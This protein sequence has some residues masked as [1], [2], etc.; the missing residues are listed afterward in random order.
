M[1]L[2]ARRTLRPS[3][4]M[5]PSHD[6]LEQAATGQPQANFDRSERRA[7][8]CESRR[9]PG[10]DRDAAARPLRRR[11]R[12]HRIG[13]ELTRTVPA[14]YGGARLDANSTSA[15]SLTRG[16]GCSCA[17][18]GVRAQDTGWWT[19]AAP[20]SAVT[21]PRKGAVRASSPGTIHRVGTT[22]SQTSTDAERAVAARCGIRGAKRA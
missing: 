21:A 1:A 20:A 12:G 22:W 7:A 4:R 6:R 11:G 8:T 5:A 13:H 2:C 10:E 3:D 15:G 16:D 18:R 17:D 14:G 9:G 19:R